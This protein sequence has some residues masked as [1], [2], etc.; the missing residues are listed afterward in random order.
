MRNIFSAISLFL[1]TFQLFAQQ[2]SHLNYKVKQGDTLYKLSIQYD[3]PIETI[4]TTNPNI[5]GNSINIGDVIRIPKQGIQ[6]ELN[7]NLLEKNMSGPKDDETVQLVVKDIVTKPAKTT[8]NV[9]I[10]GISAAE[11][12]LFAK[13][14]ADKDKTTNV[15]LIKPA[16]HIVKKGETLFSIAK[17]YG[18]EMN[19]I[20]TWNGLK[21]DGLTAGQDLI[22]GWIQPTGKALANLNKKFG[23]TTTTETKPVAPKPVVPPKPTS[24]YHKKY[25][26]FSNDKSGS[27]RLKKQRGIATWF[28]DSGETSS[29]SNLYA[30]HRS[31]PLRSIVRVT[32]PI[33][34]RSVYVMVIERLPDTPSNKNILVSLTLSAAKQLNMLDEK[35][36]VDASYY[37]T[38]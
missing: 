37:R 16:K 36:Q 10:P 1:I 8:T 7:D 32:N 11:A 2:A 18:I 34:G 22:V 28:D 17:V 25:M 23:N 29:G 12:A 6:V 27:Y 14:P 38:K 20:R 3:V 21:K 35:T 26:D 9:A 31:A 30:L 5:S 19:A 4:K 13:K 24:I 15:E 33:N